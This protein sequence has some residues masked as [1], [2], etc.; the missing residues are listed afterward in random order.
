MNSKYQRNPSERAHICDWFGK[1]SIIPNRLAPNSNR[2][3]RGKHYVLFELEY[4][5]SKAKLIMI[6]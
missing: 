2:E 5:G 6:L 4:V 1:T 3:I